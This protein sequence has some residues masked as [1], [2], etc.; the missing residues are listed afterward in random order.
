MDMHTVGSG[1]GLGNVQSKDLSIANPTTLNPT[2]IEKLSYE[3][4]S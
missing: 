4:C 3:W 1:M 2:T